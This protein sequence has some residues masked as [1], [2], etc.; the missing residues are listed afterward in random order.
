MDFI[1][2]VEFWVEGGKGGNGSVSFRR[3]KFVPKGGP[4]GGDGGDG[5]SVVLRTDP[6]V[7]TLYDLRHRKR[8]RAGRGMHGKGKKMTGRNGED[9]VLAVPVGT[10]V[11]ESESGAVLADLNG[12]NE[13]LVAARGGRGGR[14]NSHF[15]TSTRQAPDFAEDGKDGES[16]LLGLELKLLADVGLV[17]FPNSGKSTLLSRISA[18]RPKIADYPFTTLV[19]NLGIASAGEGR[20]F[21]VADIPGLIAG[22]HLGRGLGDRFLRHIERTRVLVFLIEA[23]GTEPENTYAVLLDELKRFDPSLIE[24]PRILVF[25]KSDLLS[26]EERQGL[27]PRVGG[28]EAVVLSSVSG[29]NVQRLL[30]LAAEKLAGAD[31]E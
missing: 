26:E 2:E 14:G 15:A 6:G 3:E 13:T 1:D 17:G 18:A 21:T 30:G 12:R 22:A 27:P 19:P 5:G 11:K 8:F 20:N 9:V 4:D 31:H 24:K 10:L 29:E 16:R 7:N 25:S 28:Q 23:S